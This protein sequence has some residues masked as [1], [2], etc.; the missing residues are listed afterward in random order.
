M[1]NGKP[2][3]YWKTFYINGTKKSEGV[4][5][6]FQLDSLWNFYDNKGNITK[7]ISYKNGKRN[8]YYINY[9]LVKDSIEKNIAISKELYVNDLKQGVSYYYYNNGMLHTKVS[10]RDNLKNGSGIEYSE[11][12]IIITLISYRNDVIIGKE[13]INRYNSNNE[14]TGAWKEFYN[15]GKIK[16][17][18]YYKNG[19]L[20]G[21]MKSYSEKGELLSS[22][23]YVKGKIYVED[24]NETQKAI[25]K[26]T[27]HK[28]GIIK[29]E[30]AFLK[31]KPVGIHRKF[32][33]KGNIIDSKTFS[34][35]SWVAAKG[36]VDKKEKKQG[37]WTYFY[38]NKN[39]KA[40]GAYKDDKNIGKWKYY[41]ENGN[42]EQK[43]QYN[44]NGELTGEWIW[45]FE[46]GNIN[47]KEEFINN[48]NEGIFIEYDIDSNIIN[49]GKYY[50]GYK[51]GEWIHSVGDD[52]QK[53]KYYEGKKTKV[54]KY[55]YKND[56]IRAV[57]EYNDGY[58]SGKFKYYYENGNLK[59]EGK[60]SAG[61][62][63]KTWRYFTEEGYLRTTIDYKFDKEIKIDGKNIIKNSRK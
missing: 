8:G 18:E 60:Y 50:N 58:E 54:W 22:Q 26:K 45:Y 35:N 13:L 14:K 7:K 39:I 37:K 19:K 56:K 25:V 55:Y 29:T 2:N 27:Y 62:K 15:S 36:I 53:G 31:N 34:E 21:Y 10:Y 38:K 47:K 24:K 51:T 12:S 5:T 57:G 4:R 3:G 9:K 20:N 41:F 6:N 11:K 61:Q 43:G 16:K 30:G 28:N 49:K 32:S 33:T 40:T 63:H 59:M 44:N 52:L 1:K 46:N 48:M 42:I 17:E 23:R